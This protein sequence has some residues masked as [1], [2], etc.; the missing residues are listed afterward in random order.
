VNFKDNT[1]Y[2]LYP[3]L[4][5]SEGTLGII[6]G[7][8]MKCTPYLPNRQTMMVTISLLSTSTSNGSWNMTNPTIDDDNNRTNIM[9]CILQIVQV[10]H[11]CFGEIL[12]AVEWMDPNIIHV[13]QKSFD[14]DAIQKTKF[15]HL[16]LSSTITTPITTATSTAIS[17][18]NA[19]EVESP[20]LYPHC[21]LIETH[22][23]NQQHDEEKC[24]NFL[25]AL[26]EMNHSI[27]TTAADTRRQKEDRHDPIDMNEPKNTVPFI[28]DVKMAKSDTDSKYLW[29]IRESANPSVTKL[30]YTYK[31]DV[32]IPNSLF[33]LL[34]QPVYERIYKTYT[35]DRI[36]ITN[37]GHILD[38]NLHLNITDVGNSQRD[39][40]LASILEPFIYERVLQLG[41]SISAEHGIGQ[42]K[43]RYMNQIHDPTTLQMM[44]AVKDIFDP[45]G[46]MNP[47]KVLP[48]LPEPT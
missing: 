18:A 5:G 35:T 20:L 41:G 40:E 19:V 15:Q 22:G 45:A 39:V 43:T 2:K 28:V 38:G 36:V 34:I 29:S 7:V 8:T 13:I 10:A 44:R 14:H 46:I 37:W 3:L 25:N 12:A 27:D 11:G 17:T 33:H 6:T 48:P 32:S 42:I 31:Y 9:D 1:G 26:M 4:I 16:L 21:L 47:G 23:T 30:G 24:Y